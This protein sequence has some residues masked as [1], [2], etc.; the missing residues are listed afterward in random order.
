MVGLLVD[1]CG[2]PLEIGC[3]EGDKAE[4][5]TIIPIINQFIE[6][7]GLTNMVIVADAG[8]CRRRT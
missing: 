6:R 1:R 3:F 8:C 4:T 5:L 2:L 7:H